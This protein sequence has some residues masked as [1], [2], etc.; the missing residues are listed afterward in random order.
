M[1]NN[2]HNGA[3]FPVAHP[4]RGRRVSSPSS[5]VF[6]LSLSFSLSLRLCN[7]PL[8]VL[9]TT[10]SVPAIL[11]SR[12]SR[13]WFI[14][15]FAARFAI[16]LF[17]QLPLLVQLSARRFQPLFFPWFSSTVCLCVVDSEL[18]SF[19]CGCWMLHWYWVLDYLLYFVDTKKV[20][21]FQEDWKDFGTRKEIRRVY[22]RMKEYLWFRI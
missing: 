21:C 8:F 20:A 3:S 10:R 4:L 13:R 19:Q 9:Y 18:S 1:T 16:L 7:S 17:H 15:M 14:I 12:Q 5:P 6:T 11:H 22:S 2:S